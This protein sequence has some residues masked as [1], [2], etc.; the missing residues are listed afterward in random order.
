M[1]CETAVLSE[2]S[3]MG[4]G[5]R[6]KRAH[7]ETHAYRLAPT[8]TRPQGW[9]DGLDA[10]ARTHVHTYSIALRTKQTAPP[11]PPTPPPRCGAWALSSRRLCRTTAKWLPPARPASPPPQTTPAPVYVRTGE[12]SRLIRPPAILPATLPHARPFPRL[13]RTLLLH[14]PHHRCHQS[15]RARRAC[16]PPT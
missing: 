1:T 9:T 5:K 14:V 10:S 12:R 15:P 4:L 2:D 16:P 11:P 7:R 13:L 3:S 6:W 8:C